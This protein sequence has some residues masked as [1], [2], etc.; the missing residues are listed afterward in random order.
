MSTSRTSFAQVPGWVIER[1]TDAIDLRIYT[2]LAWKHSDKD[3]YCFP[4]EEKIAE[5][6]GYGVRTVQR[7]IQRMRAVG[8]LRVVRTRKPDGHWGRNAY[9]LPMDDPTDTDMHPHQAPGQAAGPEQQKDPVFAGRNQPPGQAGRQPPTQAGREPDPQKQPHPGLNHISEADASATAPAGDADGA[10]IRDLFG[11]PQPP[12][13]KA[14]GS[15]RKPKPKPA[16]EN[17]A[18]GSAQQVVAA[19]VDAYKVNRVRPSAQRVK[20]VGREA[21][22]LLAAGND[23]AGVVAAAE[24]AARQGYATIDREFSK[25]AAAAAGNTHGSDGDRAR[26]GGYRPFT[27]LPPEEQQYEELARTGGIF[28]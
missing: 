26:N 23:L 10:T 1:V 2:H 18:A 15:A 7:A 28:R 12:A 9:L 25:L 16:Q 22:E 3:R 8:A 20:Q 19:W 5:D 13:S 14:R 24:S 6:L 27:Q 4:S 21:K 17:P 11:Q